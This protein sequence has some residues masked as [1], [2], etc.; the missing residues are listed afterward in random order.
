MDNAVAQKWS[1]RSMAGI[2]CV[3]EFPSLK[4]SG[5]FEAYNKVIETGEPLDTEMYYESER[6]KNHLRIKAVKLSNEQLV[7]FAED[8][9]ERKKAEEEIKKHLAILQN[10]EQMAQAGSWEYEISSGKFTWSEGM[11]RMFGLP[12]QMFVHPEIY[13]DFAVEEDRSIAKRIVSSIKKK[14]EP[15]EDTVKIKRENEYRLLKI[16]GS[17][18]TDEKGNPQKVIGVDLD[19]TEVEK[20]E[21]KLKE[22]QHWLEQTTKASPDSITVYDLQKK[23]PIYLNNCLG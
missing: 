14:H 12:Q 15:F 19:I 22:S 10:T 18:V 20:A 6:F 16:K 17:L 3:D 13:M 2:K 4:T 5:L 8:I 1:G 7:V 21:E 23:Q 9:T 11:Y